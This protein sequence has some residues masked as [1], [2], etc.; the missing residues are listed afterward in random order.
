MYIYNLD[1]KNIFKT[2]LTE[3]LSII[4]EIKN[5]YVSKDEFIKQLKEVSKIQFTDTRNLFNQGSKERQ[6]LIDLTGTDAPD[7]FSIEATYSKGMLVK[8]ARFLRKQENRNLVIKG[9]DES[10]FEK[11]YNSEDLTQ[12]IKIDVT[13]NDNGKYDSETVKINLLSKL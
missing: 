7:N 9:K 11:I 4:F 5:I 10:G 3:K 6:A 12:K 1:K 2:F 8:I 13:K